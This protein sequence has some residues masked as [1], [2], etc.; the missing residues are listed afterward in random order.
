MTKI[1]AIETSCDDTSAAV[2]TDHY[3]VISNVVSSQ[4]KHNDFGGV[5]PEIASRLHLQMIMNVTQFALQ[6]V[7]LLKNDIDAI[8][9][10]INPGLI[11]SLLV[12]VSFAKS[13]AYSLQKPLIA[14]NHMLGHL[15]SVRL[16]NPD[17]KPPYLALIVSGGHT[18]LVYF[19]NL[20]KFVVVGRTKDD[21][22]GEAFDKTAKLLGLG[23][24]GGPAIQKVAK[25][26]DSDF[27]KFPQALRQKNNFDF[28]FSGLKTAVKNYISKQTDEFLQIHTSDIAASLQSAIVK[29]LVNKTI[30]FTKQNKISTIVL[31]G[32]VSANR[33]LREE[34]IKEASFLG[35][36][37]YFPDIQYCMD[38]AA[39]IGAAALDK[40]YRNEFSPLELNAFSKKGLRFL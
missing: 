7:N 27:V 30:Q 11:G 24:P 8:A 38:N 17:L 22:A 12:G 13:M 31:A 6:K 33:T 18:E 14:V 15:Y 40:Y 25:I 10:S 16:T 1:L 34:M 2:I 21:A 32:G 19:K 20:Q 26:G 4:E 35:A 9:V 39:M 5:V 36:K 23:Y 28:S 37:V 3:K 29:S